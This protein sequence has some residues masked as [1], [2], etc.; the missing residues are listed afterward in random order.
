MTASC[1]YKICKITASLLRGLNSDHCAHCITS[2]VCWIFIHLNVHFRLA[3]AEDDIPA[4]SRYSPVHDVFHVVPG[5][6]GVR[7]GVLSL[8]V[9]VLILDRGIHY[10]GR[11]RETRKEATRGERSAGIRRG[12]QGVWWKTSHFLFRFTLI[13]FFG[14]LV[15]QAKSRRD[16]NTEE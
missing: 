16:K 2:S 15:V 7:G 3:T 12:I 1:T 11:H 6:D 4:C 9:T 8:R 5:I 14:R 10:D 13:K